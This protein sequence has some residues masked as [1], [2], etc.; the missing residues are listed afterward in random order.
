MF[1]SLSG[2]Y[3]PTCG[4]QRS[5]HQLLHLNFLSSLRN[6]LFLL[7]VM[8][9]AVYRAAFSVPGNKTR[10]KPTKPLFR[11]KWLWILLALVLVYTVLRNI[12]EHPFTLLAP[13]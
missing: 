5:L 2:L 8:L 1:H 10:M 7:P 13:E 4:A 12:R 9:F 11:K 6:N 3:C